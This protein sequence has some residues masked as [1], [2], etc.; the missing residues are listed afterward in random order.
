MSYR[1]LRLA[2]VYELSEEKY[3]Q[4]LKDVITCSDITGFIPDFME[5]EFLKYGRL[6]GDLEH[7]LQLDPSYKDTLELD[8]DGEE[9][10]PGSLVDP[11]GVLACFELTLKYGKDPANW[12]KTPEAHA[13]FKKEAGLES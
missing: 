12:P 4:L 5:H 1:V 6:V 11:H 10:D 13:A 8:M 7:L 9:D 3:R 2:S